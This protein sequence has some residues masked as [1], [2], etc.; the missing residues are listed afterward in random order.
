MGQESRIPRS[1]LKGMSECHE[2]AFDQCNEKCSRKFFSTGWWTS[3]KPTVLQ[4]FLLPLIK[5]WKTW[6]S[7]PRF[8]QVPQDTE[9]APPPPSPGLAADPAPIPQN[10]HGF[11]GSGSTN[12]H[13]EAVPC[14]S[15]THPEPSSFPRALARIPTGTAGIQW[16]EPQ[17]DGIVQAG[18]DLQ[19]PLVGNILNKE[20][21]TPP[22]APFLRNT[23]ELNQSIWLHFLYTL[24]W[25]ALSTIKFWSNPSSRISGY[26]WKIRMRLTWALRNSIFQFKYLI[27]T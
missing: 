26:I 13:L 23:L 18:T 16:G 4:K 11:S 20:K 12:S 5:L 9:P 24:R 7:E 1:K 25:R 15:N 22:R 14:H 21:E 2:H 19:A 17:S 27:P 3:A 8:S 10:P 6:R